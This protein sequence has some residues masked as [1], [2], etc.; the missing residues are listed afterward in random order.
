MDLQ[1]GVGGTQ[2]FRAGNDSET[3][4]FALLE[5]SGG[6]RLAGV[7]SLTV[8]QELNIPN[9][10]IDGSSL[11]LAFNTSAGSVSEIGETRV[12]LPAG[13]YYRVSGRADLTLDNPGVTLTADFVFDPRESEIIVGVANLAFQFDNGS[14]PL[15]NVS[16]GSGAFIISRTGGTAQICGT[17]TVSA[18]LALADVEISGGF[19][20]TF[21]NMASAQGERRVNVNGTEVL[22]PA[23]TAGPYVRVTVTGATPG[24]H[25]ELDVYG[26]GLS[27][28]FVFESRSVSGAGG[29]TRK[30]I[31]VEAEHVSFDLGNATSDL[32]QLTEGAIHFII[33]EEGVAG[34]GEISA[35]LDLPNV[36]LAGRFLFRLN[37]TDTAA[38][39]DLPEGPVTLPTGPY[40]QISGCDLELAMFGIRVTGDLSIEK[41]ESA[42]GTELVLIRAADLGFN[43]GSDLLVASGGQ[44]TF[45]ILDSGV[46]GQGLVP[47]TVSAFGGSFT[48]PF[49]W[50]FNR[51][52][53]AVDEIVDTEPVPCPSTPRPAAVPR[54]PSVD[55]MGDVLD[56]LLGRLN[57]PSGPF[58]RLSL[59]AEY[60]HGLYDAIPASLELNFDGFSFSVTS[61]VLEMVEAEETAPAYVKVG[62]GGLSF[63]LGTDSLGLDLSDGR[64]AFVI[65]RGDA[66][67]G[68]AGDVRVSTVSLNTTS[69]LSVTAD[70]LHVLFNTT[71]RAVGPVTVEISEDASEDVVIEFTSDQADYLAV[72]GVAT[73]ALGIP[74]LGIDLGGNF[75]FQR[76]ASGEIQ[77]CAEELHFNLEVGGTNLASF[78]HGNGGF[79]ILEQGFAGQAQLDFEAG[80]IGISGDI[81]LEVNTT[82]A[83]VRQTVS[84]GSCTQALDLA[85]NLFKITVSD[86]HFSIGSLSLPLDFSVEVITGSGPGAGTIEV[87]RRSAPVARLIRITPGQS[88]TEAISISDLLRTLGVDLDVLDFSNPGPCEWVS[89][90]RQVLTW[91]EAF[92]DSSV[93][94]TEI[95]FTGG[96][97]VGEAFDWTRL[98]MD[99][100]YSR[101]VSVELV[102]SGLSSLSNPRV[103]GTLTDAAFTLKVGDFDAVDLM[104][105]AAY[106]S[107]DLEALASEFNDLF[108]GVRL[109]VG[110]DDVEESPGDYLLL[111]ELVEARLNLDEEFLVIALKPKGILGEYQLALMEVDDQIERLGFAR[112]QEAGEEEAPEGEESRPLAVAAENA[113]YV[114][115]AL[116][117]AIAD[118]LDDG[119]VNGSVPEVYDAARREYTY[120]MDYTD[121]LDY[122][123]PLPFNFATDLGEIAGASLTGSL[124]LN[125]QAGFSLTLGFD[126]SARDVPR[127]ISSPA[128]PVPSNGRISADAHFEIYLNGDEAHKVALTLPKADTDGNRNIDDLAAD[129]NRV[130]ADPRYEIVF[131][132]TRTPLNQLLY[133][134]KAANCLVISALQED[135]N[136]NGEL[137]PGE[138]LNGDLDP[139]P[140]NQLGLVNRI[141]VR[142]LTTDVFA[143]EMGFGL[144]L[145]ETDTD[146]VAWF[147]GSA[148]SPVK[149]LFLEN[150]NLGGRLSLTSPGGIAGSLKFGFVEVSTSGG[151]FGT[152]AYDG[153]TAAPIEATV[154]LRNRTT[155]E[156]RFYISELFDGTEDSNIRNMV[157]DFDFTGSF[158]AS[159]SNIELKAG[160]LDLGSFL[161]SGNPEIKVWIPEITELDYNSEPYEEG[162]TGI[163]VTYP[164]LA[165]LQSFAEFNFTRLIKALNAIA[166][167]LGQL[168]AFD[169]LDA[170]IPLVD[171]SVNEMLDYADKFAELIEAAGSNRTGSLQ[172]SLLELDRQV[173]QLFNL[174][175]DQF[176][177]EL[178]RNGIYQDAV[179]TTGGTASR[180][181]AAT[182]NPNGTHNDF[183]V[184]AAVNGEPF[185][186]S[187]IRLLPDASLTGNE[188]TADWDPVE[189]VLT[190]RINPDVTKA[191][192]IIAAVDALPDWNAART[193]DDDGA[194]GT[195]TNTGDGTVKTIGR[196]DL[197]TA[198]GADRAHASTTINPRGTHNGFSITAADTGA[199]LNDSIIRIVGDSAIRDNRARVEWNARDKLLTIF[200]NPGVTTAEVVVRAINDGLTNWDAVLIRDD[201]GDIAT[202]GNNGSGTILGSA[203][204]FGFHFQVAYADSLPLQLD[205]KDLVDL[206]G[207]SNSAAKTFLEVATTLVQI[208]GSMDLKVSASAE[209][210]I[211]FGLDLT[212]PGDVRPFFY[213][214]T[215]ATLLARVRGTDLELEASLGSIIGIFV[216]GGE[217]T[218]DRDGNPETD[219]GDADNPD[220]GAEFMLGLRDNNG[221]G[222]HYFNEDWLTWSSIDL[223]LT[224]GISATLPI[225][226][227]TETMAL[228]GEEDE[229]EDGYPDNCL[230]LEVPDLV[231]LF[232]GDLVKTRAVG[233]DATIL[234][235][236]PNNDL[237][238][239]SSTHSN[240]RI[241]FEN[242]LTSGGAEARFVPND[243]A[244]DVADE[245]T[246]IVRVQT[247]VTTADDVVEAFAGSRVPGFTCTLTADDDGSTETTGNDGSG[248]L[249]KLFVATPDFRALFEDI[250]FC[251]LI[252]NST[253]LLL[254][255]LDKLLR[256]IQDGLNALV[257]STELPLIGDGMSGAAN[258]IERFREGFLKDLRDAV[259]Q[260]GGNGLTALE[261][262][263][264]KG[265]WNSLGPGGIDILVDFETGEELDLEVG[266]SQ[267]DVTLDCED[268]LVVNVRLKEEYVIGTTDNPIDFDIGVRGFGLEVD[269]NVE[270]AIGFD[271]KL[272]FGFNRED[273]FYF[274]SSAPADNPELRV[275]IEARIPEL[276]VG[277]QLLFLQLD[278]SDDSEDPSHVSG[279]FVVDLKDPN[280]DGKLTFAEM[281]SSGLE[282][283]DVIDFDLVADIEVNLGLAASFGGDTAFPR[284]LAEFHLGW[285]WTLDDGAGELRI[286]FTDIYLDLGTYIS[287]F[288][289][290]I[291]EKIRSV[292][293]P[294]QPIIDVVTTPIPVISD[295]AGQPVT[296]L[297]L[298]EAFGLL[299]PST[300]RFIECV[301]KVITLI[302]EI[303]GIGEGPILIPFGSFALGEDDDGE[304]RDIQPL[305]DL[306]D[307]TMDDI[308]TLV[309]A[310][311]NPG[312]SSSQRQTT[313]RFMGN[314]SSLDNFDIP[315]FDNP[316]ELFNLFKGDPVRLIEWR[317]PTFKFE[318]TYTQS[319]PIFGPL[320]AQFGGTI[321]AKI[322]IGFGY[323]TY[324]I[325][326]YIESE[327]KKWWDILDG[328]YITDYDSS[329]NEQAELEL[330]GE[331][332]AGLSLDL[333]VVEAGVTGGVGFTVKFDLH[334]V[335]D[336]GKIRVSELI[337][338]A[339]QD[340]RCLFDING[341]IYLFLEAYLKIDFVIFQFERTWRFADLT[342]FEFTIT[343]PQ[344]VLWRADSKDIGG[345]TIS[346]VYLNIGVEAGLREHVDTSDGPETFLLNQVSLEDNTE[347]V[348]VVWGSYKAEFAVNIL[349]DAIVV[350]DAGEGDDF[351]DFRGIRTKVVVNGGEGNDTI[352]LSDGAGSKAYGGNG[353]DT[354][355]ASA[356]PTAT[357][358]IIYGGNGNDILTGGSAAIQIR[359][360][361]FER[362]TGRDTIVG[363][364]E[365]DSLYGGGDVD[366]ID[367]GGGDDY[368]EGNEGNDVIEG[369]D[370]NDFVLAGAGADQVRGSGDNDVLHGGPGDD[371]LFGGSGN[372]LLLGGD[373][374]DAVY[375]HGGSDLL[376]GDQAEWIGEEG[377]GLAIR[378]ENR[379]DLAL[380]LAAIPTTGIAVSDLHGT[381]NDFLVG[382]GGCDVLFGGDGDDCIYGGNFIPAGETEV[383]EEDHNDFIDGGRGN[384][385]IFGD[386][387]M[388]RT[389]DRN[390]G[391]AI[392]SSIYYDNDQDGVR[393][394]NETGFGQVRVEL[395]TSDHSTVATEM[396][397]ADGS[398]A[399]LGLDKGTYYLWFDLPAG[400]HF[401]PR[402][403]VEGVTSAEDSRLDSDVDPVTQRTAQFT[404]DYDETETAIAAGY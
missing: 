180:A 363:S 394:E 222:R 161:L 367:G 67:A 241:R 365:N 380:L 239:S 163:F 148:N 124:N 155:G 53:R 129:L 192:A 56:P 12:D 136:G 48:Y 167:A 308:R 33:S 395:R 22:I 57:L 273:G 93:F 30:L 173:E 302:N 331:L 49:T 292:T 156:S 92:R 182:L 400:L 339:K 300:I 281:S 376:I 109:R 353:A 386:D 139:N 183:T 36:S 26:F 349:T 257:F 10:R 128:I 41:R 377:G 1:L 138:D 344:P 178:D 94:N 253:G 29:S 370:G 275:Y 261:N 113:R 325:Q 127:I 19:S 392:R 354:I 34:Q 202:I 186:G 153:V 286:E 358:V 250:S 201:D 77:V 44:A 168:S 14:T 337:A 213:D 254:D 86:G 341:R 352:Y 272:G 364:P 277:G 146:R 169:F 390:T 203:L 164:Q 262:A 83:P 246:L 296:F 294:L 347:N 388:G 240:Y 18:S 79:V 193:A 237:R 200:I 357:G 194:S 189:K 229:D 293:E 322:N 307:R 90:L 69:A 59:D 158:L 342:L 108:S 122:D 220:K 345:E 375:G 21:N 399:F 121:A 226:A 5:E 271:L 309:D 305:E 298:A 403:A 303:E 132:G 101:L 35:A 350:L 332:F 282:F 81:R 270:L 355:T 208:R 61:L 328:F 334:D 228:G 236:G 244:R 9:F 389:G 238:I 268:G 340:P 84:V 78:D 55:E 287:D 46:A 157:P 45:V 51:T 97:T 391:I 260:A 223:H 278:V 299:E 64:G 206:I 102:A 107:D 249:E 137:D 104:L 76:S 251:D 348:E 75:N 404:L 88:I 321:G 199:G 209:L 7:A 227:P 211:V 326:K 396:T 343:C 333:A 2:V 269:G 256:V 311:D 264:K 284:L 360:D 166:D 103:T 23:L 142:T 314:I 210:H 285:E 188:A 204:K 144:R 225:Y 58:N 141:T 290:P 140:D 37:T 324:G 98:F 315:I 114:T 288:L 368:V 267:L 187:V 274:N 89:M 31:T 159:L 212:N 4:T 313:S 393:D 42:D 25:A 134:Q 118:L 197:R 170:K 283:E 110:G 312:V 195:T 258:F 3:L 279:E 62:V 289:A 318:F 351:L 297:N 232:V 116:I 242:S 6:Y 145:D 66:G 80:F 150:V 100:V 320:S 216:R 301:L 230:V 52:G 234:F 317:M 70:D 50:T 99:E 291:L 130:F 319:I 65:Y 221:D 381:G 177:A 20:V 372:D 172:S 11:T 126:L 106:T 149:G 304:R 252:A 60:L 175:S 40:L 295:L 366:T 369:G 28:D 219:P 24:T 27:G 247:D 32:V 382:G 43:F 87:W 105:S 111:D 398:F 401:V 336:D 112:R 310:A 133:A 371:Q 63:T 373:G 120:L 15:L 265:I 263:I 198:G 85:A 335:N 96:F 378:R 374:A 8:T 143:T 217:L 361:E 16:G 162:A 160:G 224:G 184:T 154:T 13:P 243:P 39:L 181:S 74:G 362:G 165:D 248:E 131:N 47:V 71:G 117:N 276:H 196:D 38:T 338:N 179:R 231:R 125:V 385:T 346:G 207:D 82:A 123:K 176:T 151:K 397:E 73:I 356:E 255:G 91:L 95:P 214:E 171:M 384:D 174:D 233:P 185:D 379:I 329:G 316:A 215:G 205:L 190:V 327:D 191:N 387:A 359:G 383:I 218:V 330:Y 119:Q 266:F 323:D 135:R 17:A 235:A 280:R 245:N 54:I 259:E 115:Q 68:V 147:V 306:A 72:S 152:L 402:Y